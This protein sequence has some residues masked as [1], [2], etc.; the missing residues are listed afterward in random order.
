MTV[1]IAQLKQEIQ[2]WYSRIRSLSKDFSLLSHYVF[3]II[4]LIFCL[5]GQ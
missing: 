2:M 1:F 5:L 3:L 4:V